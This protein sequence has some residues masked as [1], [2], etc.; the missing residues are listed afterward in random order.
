[1]EKYVSDFDKTVGNFLTKTI[2]KTDVVRGLVHLVLVLYIAKLAPELPQNVLKF[3]ENAYVKLFIFSLVLW[4]AQFSPSTSILIALG[5]MVTMNYAN[6]KPLWEFLDNVQAAPT[7]PPAVVMVH[8]KEVAIAGV[9]TVVERQISDAPIVQEIA[10]KLD[11]IVVQPKIVD[12]PSGKAVVNPN[13]VVAP[14]IVATDK[15]DKVIIKPDLTLV[16][17]PGAPGLS[18]SAGP[19]VSTQAVAATVSAAIQP[20]VSGSANDIGNA[21]ANASSSTIPVQSPPPPSEQKPEI[22]NPEA[23]CY[24]IR[25]YDMSKISGFDEAEQY[26]SA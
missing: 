11:T 1:M 20:F 7:G 3:V 24:P 14:V 23:G 12:T 13:V 10:Q 16:D 15:G 18:A 9:S 2:K 26:G 25:R 21:I 22:A 6:Q 8:N 4:T 17:A 5:F 19:A